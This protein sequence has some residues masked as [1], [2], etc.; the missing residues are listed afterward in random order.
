MLNNINNI[1]LLCSFYYYYIMISL[2][3]E[4]S[5]KFYF[6]VEEALDFISAFERI[7]DLVVVRTKLQCILKISLLLNRSVIFNYPLLIDKIV[8]I[9][10][11]LIGNPN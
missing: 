4:N 3:L 6:M 9:G 7:A 5:Y 11:K 10:E 1:N 2:L 8:R